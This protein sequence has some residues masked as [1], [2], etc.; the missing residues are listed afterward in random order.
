[1]ILA[2]IYLALVC[3]LV[4]AWLPENKLYFNKL[5]RNLF[6]RIIKFKFNDVHIYFPAEL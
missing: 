5:S 3:G 6:Q 2:S 1:M 4:V